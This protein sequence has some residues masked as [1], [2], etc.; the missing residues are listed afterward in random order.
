MS[1]VQNRPLPFHLIKLL[2][3]LGKMR[4]NVRSL[5]MSRHVQ[6]MCGLLLPA[7]V[8]VFPVLV[9]PVLIFPVFLLVRVRAA[10]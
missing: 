4:S 8:G 7:A 6:A 3:Q 2:R 9:F 10:A 1:E 5:L